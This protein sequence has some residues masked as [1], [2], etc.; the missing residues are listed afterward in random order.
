MFSLRYLIFSSIF[1]FVVTGCATSAVDDQAVALPTEADIE[2]TPTPVRPSSITPATVSPTPSATAS[3]TFAPTSLPTV[4]PSPTITPT[5]PIT[6]TFRAISYTETEWARII[7][8]QNIHR[9]LLS[10]DHTLIAAAFIEET[11]VIDVATG[12]I[13]WIF[14][15]DFAAVS[16]TLIVLFSPDSTLLIIAGAEEIVYVWN[17]I[18]GELVYKFPFPIFIM[19]A[20][21]TSDGRYLAVGNGGEG[22]GFIYV[23]DLFDGTWIEYPEQM[24]FGGYTTF[25]PDSTVLAI[26][27]QGFDLEDGAILLWDFVTGDERI[28]LPVEGGGDFPPEYISGGYLRVSPSGNL[29]AVEVNDSIHLWDIHSK[30]EIK[31]QESPFDNRIERVLFSADDNFAIQGRDNSITV[32]NSQGRLL[33]S[34]RNDVHTWLWFSPDGKYL[35]QFSL[36]DEPPLVWEIPDSP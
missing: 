7:E 25:L 26:S 6:S 21:L 19:T 23:Y 8:L 17:V 9:G 14:E 16:G 12:D 10:P 33:G 13:K 35:V 24:F 30:V 3:P 4:T 36:D 2:E 32:W 11:H 34:I 20:D 22:G 27:R 1:I 31:L 18:T 15:K 29:M 28:V 5:L